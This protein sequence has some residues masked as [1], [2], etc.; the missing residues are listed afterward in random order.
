MVGSHH[1]C[2]IKWE[3]VLRLG[4]TIPLR[5]EGFEM[6]EMVTPRM[7]TFFR[8]IKSLILV[9]SKFERI[10]VSSFGDLTTISTPMGR[11]HIETSANTNDYILQS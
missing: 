3:Q 2:D 4:K 11:P 1:S 6:M 8:E 10:T 9:M 7:D 5:V